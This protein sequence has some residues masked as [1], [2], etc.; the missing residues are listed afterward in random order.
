[1]ALFTGKIEPIS[2]APD[3][4]LCSFHQIDVEAL[5]R[6]LRKKPRYKAYKALLS[7]R[8]VLECLKTNLDLKAK[9]AVEA[10]QKAI[11]DYNKTWALA[12]ACHVS[13]ESSRA[14][15]CPAIA[16]EM[17]DTILEWQKFYQDQKVEALEECAVEHGRVQYFLLALNKRVEKVEGA[18]VTRYGIW[19]TD[20]E[21]NPL[22][23]CDVERV[24][25]VMASIPGNK[26]IRGVD[27]VD[28]MGM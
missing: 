23:M 7:H 15:K 6:A 9:E 12:H 10:R 19:T 21:G 11:N 2:T 3:G 27:W 28:E 1:M 18:L 24:I 14:I 17:L 4:K 16:G 5:C 8:R 22:D 13:T 20:E 25:D 26:G